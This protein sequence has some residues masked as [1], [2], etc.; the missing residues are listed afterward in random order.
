MSLQN[1]LTARQKAAK[2]VGQK[3]P[4]NK[5]LYSRLEYKAKKKFPSHPSQQSL[6]WLETE[7]KKRGGTYQGDK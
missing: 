5:R 7:Y 2:S 6:K 4:T 3:Q 1:Y